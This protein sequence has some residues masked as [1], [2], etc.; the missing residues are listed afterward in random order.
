[1][2][3]STCTEVYVLVSIALSYPGLEEEG[4]VRVV[5]K[6]TRGREDRGKRGREEVEG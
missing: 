3:P 5:S 2:W 4:M 1:M 6:R